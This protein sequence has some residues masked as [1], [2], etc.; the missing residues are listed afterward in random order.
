MGQ[1]DRAQDR[2]GP[3]FKAGYRDWQLS[4]SPP[5]FYYAEGVRGGDDWGYERGRLAACWL[6]VSGEVTPAASDRRR[7]RTVDGGVVW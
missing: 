2:R 1:H 5:R 7:L 4:R 3:Q 6:Q